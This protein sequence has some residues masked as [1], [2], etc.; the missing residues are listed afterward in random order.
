MKSRHRPALLLRLLGTAQQTC[1]AGGD[2]T[3][4][5]TLG[6]VAGNGRSLT[7]M[8][9]VTTTVGMVDGVHG[10][11]TSLGPAVALDGELVL[12]ARSLEEGLVGTATTG[13]DTDHTTGA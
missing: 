3:G 4:L 13:D 6:G 12:G 7:N 11:T 1:P 8:L 9:V 10:H 5:L 2:E